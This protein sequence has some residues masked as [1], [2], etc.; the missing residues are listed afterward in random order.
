VWGYEIRV[1]REFCS[2]ERDRDVNPFA[3]NAIIE[4]K[5]VC[6]GDGDQRGG[7]ELRRLGLG[8]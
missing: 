5:F 1:G 7:A 3:K 8:R 2:A 6:L 4:R